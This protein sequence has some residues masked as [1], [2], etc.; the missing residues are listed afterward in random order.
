MLPWKAPD[1]MDQNGRSTFW[2]VVFLSFFFNK[3]P[4]KNP[5][6]LPPRE[7]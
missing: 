7:G 5:K 3:L 6:A 4:K 2:S 1:F